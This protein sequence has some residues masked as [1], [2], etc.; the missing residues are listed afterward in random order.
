MFSFTLDTLTVCKQTESLSLMNQ[1]CSF[2]IL[3][4]RYKNES[5]NKRPD[6]YKKGVCGRS[7]SVQCFAV[8]VLVWLLSSSVSVSVFS[9]LMIQHGG[10]AQTQRLLSLPRQ[11]GVFVFFV[12]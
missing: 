5:L 3:S 8:S 7:L 2:T 10:R 11:N 12:L 4:S 9:M 6:V 1:C